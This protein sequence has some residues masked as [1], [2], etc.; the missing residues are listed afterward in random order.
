MPTHSQKELSGGNSTLAVLPEAITVLNWPFGE[1]ICFPFGDRLNLES[2]KSKT[3]MPS[4][5]QLRQ[6]LVIIEIYPKG[7]PSTKTLML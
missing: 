5:Q 1:K 2:N 6:Q 7:F 4:Q 3:L